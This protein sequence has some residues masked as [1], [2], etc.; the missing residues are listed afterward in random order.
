MLFK[1]PVSNRISKFY[2]IS[3]KIKVLINSYI[4]KK[5]STH[6]RV[7]KR[8]QNELLVRNFAMPPTVSTD[9]AKPT[10]RSV[11]GFK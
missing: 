2:Y 3:I 1:V 9:V 5:E 11:L 7:D 6:T 8:S 10:G 4:Q